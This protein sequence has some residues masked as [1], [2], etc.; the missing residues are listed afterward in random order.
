MGN[1]AKNIMYKEEKRGEFV[2]NSPLFLSLKIFVENVK[3]M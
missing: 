1:R 3:N 2:I